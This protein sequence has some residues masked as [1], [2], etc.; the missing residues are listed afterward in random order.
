MW[1]ILHIEI[2][3]LSLWC[4]RKFTEKSKPSLACP[5]R[6][7]VKLQVLDD[8]VGGQNSHHLI[9]QSTT[10]SPLDPVKQKKCIETY[11]IFIRRSSITTHK[12]E[13]EEEHI[14]RLP[15]KRS[16]GRTARFPSW[17]ENILFLH[18]VAVS[19]S[20]VEPK[21]ETSPGRKEW[22]QDV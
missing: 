2:V 7:I 17:L 20:E 9:L 15:A 5:S 10:I 22:S 19:R 18:V 14:R 13:E 21:P 11:H 8:R 1:T 3:R 16:S 4:S 12:E 6:M